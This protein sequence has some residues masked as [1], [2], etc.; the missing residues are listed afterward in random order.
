MTASD[1][2]YLEVHLIVTSRINSA[3]VGVETGSRSD[4]DA[5]SPQSPV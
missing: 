3:P 5:M 4:A 2:N 1:P